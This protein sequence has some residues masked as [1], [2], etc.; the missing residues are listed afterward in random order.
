MVIKSKSG[1]CL[2]MWQKVLIIQYILCVLWKKKMSHYLVLWDTDD[3]QQSGE[4]IVIQQLL[5]STKPRESVLEK[6]IYMLLFIPK[7]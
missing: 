7:K 1:P 2:C 4:I 5:H 3:V 6:R